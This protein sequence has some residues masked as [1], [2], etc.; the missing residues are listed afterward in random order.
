[1]E[2]LYSPMEMSNNLIHTPSS[3]PHLSFDVVPREMTME[4]A[5]TPWP[6]EEPKM[7]LTENMDY[8]FGEHNLPYSFLSIKTRE[9]GEMWYR[10]NTKV[11]ECMVP[12]LA[13]YHWGDLHPKYPPYFTPQ[14]KKKKKKSAKPDLKFE[15]NTGKFKVN[16]D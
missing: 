5:D 3:D 6:D 7:T 1:M 12:Y 11:P 13:R 15:R 9:E 10:M 8:S 16:F 2:V 4:D 14:K